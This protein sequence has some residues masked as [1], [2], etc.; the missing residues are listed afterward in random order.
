[1]RRRVGQIVVLTAVCLFAGKLHI[2][3]QNAGCPLDSASASDNQ[4][5]F[6]PEIS[7]TGVTFSGFI[8]LPITDQDRIAFSIKRQTHGSRLDSV[9]EEGLERVRAGWQNHGYF[10]VQVSGDASTISSSPVSQ[11]IV[12]NVHVDEGSQYS[13]GGITFKHNRAISN[14]NA[15]RALFPIKN[16]EVFSREKIAAGLENLRKAYGQYG[17]INY[18]GV[19]DSTFDNEKKLA[20]LEIDIDEGKQFYLTR[21]DILGLD[22][23]SRQEILKDLQVGQIYNQ[24]LFDLF[25]EKHAS[26]FKFLHDDPSHVAKRLDERAGTVEITLGSRPC[27]VD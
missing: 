3:A 1:M 21:V 16:G 10:K 4:K 7:I 9:I 24:R 27:P 12:L 22:E 26:T 14:V 17:Y 2:R 25:L 20:S 13:L 6:G 8:Q 11:R 18:T 5:P 23:T 19:P 15:L